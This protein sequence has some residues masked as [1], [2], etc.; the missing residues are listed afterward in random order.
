MTVNSLTWNQGKNIEVNYII[1]YNDNND[2]DSYH[3]LFT[4]RWLHVKRINVKF[5]L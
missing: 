3:L 5:S 1:Y 2:S 4:M